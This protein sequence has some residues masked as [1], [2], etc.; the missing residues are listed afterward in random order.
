MRWLSFFK[1][2]FS[3]DEIKRIDG[4]VYEKN[5]IKA[6]KIDEFPTIIQAGVSTI[7][8]FDDV[9]IDN[10]RLRKLSETDDEYNERMRL[11]DEQENK[12]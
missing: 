3:S 8:F 2:L 11:L 9:V 7:T 6:M 12:C 5:G 1:S 4:V 10:P